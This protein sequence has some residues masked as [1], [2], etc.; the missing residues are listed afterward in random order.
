MLPAQQRLPRIARPRARWISKS[1]RAAHGGEG[2]ED[3]TSPSTGGAAQERASG[4]VVL[5][6]VWQQ[7]QR[8]PVAAAWVEMAQRKA[9]RRRAAEQAARWRA[10]LS[11][12]TTAVVYRRRGSSTCGS[13]TD[14]SAT[15]PT[16]A[17]TP[18]SRTFDAKSVMLLMS[19]LPS[20][21]LLTGT[22]PG[23]T[24]QPPPIFVPEHRATGWLPT[25]ELEAFRTTLQGNPVDFRRAH[26]SD[27]STKPS[28]G[29]RNG[30][31]TTSPRACRWT[32]FVS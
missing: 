9:A 18:H 16:K 1:R 23:T 29:G 21:P 7:R 24:L 12:L 5:R 32:V 14:G 15:P 27:C 25:H 8:R 31:T 6:L 11:R 4:Q 3:S 28:A 30:P 10:M 20:A 13:S 17:L 22:S 26:V 2:G 19:R